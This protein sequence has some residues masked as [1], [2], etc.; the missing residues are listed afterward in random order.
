V[1]NL[2]RHGLWKLLGIEYFRFLKRQHKVYLDRAPNTQIGYKTYHNGACVWQWYPNSSLT[3]GSYCSIANDVHFILDDGFHQQS[4]ISSFPHLDHLKNNKLAFQG[5]SVSDFKAS[6]IPA[7]TT[8]TIGHDVW[9]GMHATLLPGI[10]VGSGATIMAGAVVASDVPPYAVVGGVP[11]RV[12][13]MKHSPAEIQKLLDIAWWHWPPK[14]VE[15]QAADFYLP[16]PEFI[17]KW[18]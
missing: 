11:A 3:I 16:T 13:K 2:L 10:T 18:S 5:Q 4:S 1:K 15:T 7:P 17:Q 6:K 14:Q 9:I 8:T 12:V